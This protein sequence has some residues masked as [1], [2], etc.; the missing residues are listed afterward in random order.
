V[1]CLLKDYAAACIYGKDRHGAMVEFNS[2]RIAIELEMEDER[3][4]ADEEKVKYVSRY[5]RDDPC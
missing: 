4:I 3:V 2:A 5:L 1:V